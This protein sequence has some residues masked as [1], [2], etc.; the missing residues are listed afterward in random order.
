MGN[1]FFRTFLWGV[2]FLSLAWGQGVTLPAVSAEEYMKR[3]VSY[4]NP[5]EAQ[6]WVK[7]QGK[8]FLYV[9]TKELFPGLGQ[10]LRGKTVRV[11]APRGTRTISWL[12]R[13]SV[14]Y[15]LVVMP[16]EMAGDQ[17]VLLSLEGYMMG[18]DSNGRVMLLTNKEV[19]AVVARIFQVYEPFAKEV[20]KR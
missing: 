1:R 9:G 3:Y 2:L 16:G 11:Y 19:V 15:T 20:V 13:A 6:R 10:A 4:P 14:S 8:S 7:T 12:D 5:T 17:G 18:L